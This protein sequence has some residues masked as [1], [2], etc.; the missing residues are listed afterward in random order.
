MNFKQF[1]SES[2]SSGYSYESSWN[3]DLTADPLY[4]TWSKLFE[5]IAIF[6]TDKNIK[7]MWL[8]KPDEAN[9][10]LMEVGFVI[11]NK[12]RIDFSSYKSGTGN[13]F[14][15]FKTVINIMNDFLSNTNTKGITFHG[16]KKDGRNDLYVKMVK[17]NLPSG[18]LFEVE[19]D[20]T[21]PLF[22]GVVADKYK[23]TKGKLSEGKASVS[24]NTIERPN[25]DDPFYPKYQ[26]MLT[27]RKRRKFKRL[28]ENEQNITTQDIL[29]LSLYDFQI[30]LG[31]YLD[32]EENDF[33]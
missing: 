18:C 8:A 11:V 26:Q 24:S 1:L 12:E 2:T 25:E 6:E 5:Y 4:I 28:D 29:Q 23:I 19:K 27:K 32:E 13:E 10:Q 9:P 31:D 14:K 22:P 16:D 7:Y 33:E 20:I 15:V 21:H 3:N 17:R 30:M